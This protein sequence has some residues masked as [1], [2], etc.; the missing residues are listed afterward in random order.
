MAQY[1][2]AVG[3]KTASAWELKGLASACM[4]F[5]ILCEYPLSLLLAFLC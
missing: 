4:T 1:L 2:Y 5:I 3:G